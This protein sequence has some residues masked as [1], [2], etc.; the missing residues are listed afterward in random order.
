MLEMSGS[1]EVIDPDGLMMI[2]PEHP[3][4]LNP[5]DDELS[6]LARAAWA[7]AVGEPDPGK[8]WRGTHG[9]VCGKSSDNR[10]YY[11]RGLKTNSLL[12]HYVEYHR[13]DVPQAE[14]RKL[15]LFSD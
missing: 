15:G 8:W 12:V 9:C 2:E 11:V 10:D 5:V 13:E 7:E 1:K 4:S 3:R 6:K 14:L